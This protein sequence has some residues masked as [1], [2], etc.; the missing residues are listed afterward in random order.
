MFHAII[1]LMKFGKLLL[2]GLI[3]VFL[4]GCLAQAPTINYKNNEVALNGLDSVRTQFNFTMQNPNILALNGKI[5]YTFFV[6]GQEF[7]SGQSDQIS[8][9]A[10][11]ETEFALR[12]DIA[13]EKVFGSASELV[14]AVV[15]GQKSIKVRVAG[16][17][18]TRALGFIEIP[19]RIDQETDVPLPDMKE[20]EKE[21]GNQLE[22]QI[23]QGLQQGL[24]NLFK[25]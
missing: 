3:C 23:K 18:K 1:H 12:Q 25:F 8:A 19:I 4:T 16:E 5:D 11:G 21:L 17:Y 15:K 20:V 6:A 7:F 14:N 24:E 2:T 13:F 9:P 22:N 10:G